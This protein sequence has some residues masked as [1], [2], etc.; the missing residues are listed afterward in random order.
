MGGEV[1]GYKLWE[2]TS[3]RYH[4]DKPRAEYK[5]ESVEIE[6]HNLGFCCQ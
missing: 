5:I 2:G 3:H 6:T 1:D 4:E